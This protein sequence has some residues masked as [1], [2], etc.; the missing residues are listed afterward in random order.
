M[1]DEVDR[2]LDTRN[3]GEGEKGRRMKDDGMRGMKT[4]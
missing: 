3:W 4:N 1:K 2:K